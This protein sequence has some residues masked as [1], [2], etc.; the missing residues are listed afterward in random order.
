MPG[1]AEH[2]ITV[3]MKACI[4]LDGSCCCDIIPKQKGIDLPNAAASCSVSDWASV[5]G[6]LITVS[7]VFLATLTYLLFSLDK[8]SAQ[9]E[10]MMPEGT[11]ILAW[12]C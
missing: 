1:N 12:L 9:G 5:V 10:I 3:T 4:S 6:M 2:H 11:I 8:T 7:H